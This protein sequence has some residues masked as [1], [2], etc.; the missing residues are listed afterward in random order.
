MAALLKDNKEA[1]RHFAY[2]A[3]VEDPESANE[4]QRIFRADS[5]IDTHVGS[6]GVDAAI[7]WLQKHGRSP[8]R[9]LVDISAAARPLDALDRLAD[10]CEPSVEV[11]ALGD[12]NDVGLFRNLLARGVQDYLIK[13]LS[14]ELL[15]R[16]LMQGGTAVRRSRHGKCVAVMGTRGGVGTTAI[17]TQLARALAQGGTRRRVVYLDLNVYDGGG[18]AMLGCPAGSALLDVLGNIDRLDPQ[19]LERA[20]ADAGDGI[21]VLA[22]ELDYSEP[23]APQ[24]G[25]LGALLATLRLHF[26]YVIMD[27]PSRAGA[28]AGEALAHA[29]QVC[30][31]GEPSVHSART[32]VRLNRHVTAQTH[33][34]TVVTVLNHP[35]PAT[36]H[37]VRDRDFEQ[38]VEL[39]L[40]LQIPHDPKAPVLAENM[41]QEMPQSCDF[42]RAVKN[43][44]GLITGGGIAPARQ[45]W[46]RLMGRASA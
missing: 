28:L 26:H 1:G 10:A 46:W 3:F 31:V 19:Y 13:P 5:L 42:A 34:P 18:P 29:T 14:V 37:R 40:S 8:H 15:R 33:S 43:L 30:L 32:L 6:G 4:L 16:T 22:A 44:A 25:A 41:A 21:H 12:R 11:Y 17:A 24:E 27:V 36:R 2:A 39:S 23:F 9:L 7:A 20:L 35:V 45:A 38:A